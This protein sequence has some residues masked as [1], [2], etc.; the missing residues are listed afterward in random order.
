MFR[1]TLF[2]DDKRLAEVLHNLAGLAAGM[3]EV[4]PVV[5]GAKKNGK[6]V[7]AGSGDHPE[8]F[9]KYATHHKLTKFPATALREY[10]LSHGMAATS[11]SY[12]AKQLVQAGVLKKTGKG[13]KATYT[14]AS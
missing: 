6:V 1:V 7:A 11:Y 10:C 5:N 12:L 8:M 9:L 3:P 2:C 4:Q 14:V 13:T